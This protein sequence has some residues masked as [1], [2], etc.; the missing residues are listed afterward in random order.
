MP[1]AGKATITLIGLVGQAWAFVSM[2]A[3]ANP[4]IDS[5]SE[6]IRFILVSS[7]C[8]AL[9]WRFGHVFAHRMRVP[10]SSRPIY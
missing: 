6:R 10:G 7:K 8:W 5:D 9:L 1:P 3:Q 4:R 2:L